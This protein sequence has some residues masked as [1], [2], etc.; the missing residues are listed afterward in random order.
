M[1]LLAYE[2]CSERDGVAAIDACMKSGA[3]EI[4]HHLHVWTT[5]PFEQ[6]VKQGIDRAWLHAFQFELPDNLFEDKAGTLKEAIESAFGCT[7]RSHRA[8]RWGVDQRTIDWLSRNG[9]LVDTSVVLGVSWKRQTGAAASGPEFLAS[10][11]DPMRWYARSREEWVIE[12]PTSTVA[13]RPLLHLAL[14]KPAR[15]Y[16]SIERLHKKL[17]GPRMLR[18]DPSRERDPATAIRT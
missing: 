18:P 15:R 9:F 4:G 10:P 6:P 2:C 5:P 14:R 11:P 16:R 12:L 17:A 7:P 8:G 3:C 1:Y 13:T